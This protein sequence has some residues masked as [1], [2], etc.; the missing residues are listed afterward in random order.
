MGGE[1]PLRVFVLTRC[2]EALPG[3]LENLKSE[4]WIDNQVSFLGQFSKPSLEAQT[5]VGFEWLV[6]ASDRLAPSSLEK[7]RGA[8]EP[9][10]NLV[11]QQG[12]EH[13]SEVFYRA[14]AAQSVP[15]VTVL[16]DYDDVLSPR[17]IENVKISVEENYEVYSFISGLVYD[18]EHRIAAQWP[19]VSNPF[20]FHVGRHGSNVFGLGNHT[21]VESKFGSQLKVIR[22]PSPM[23]VKIVHGQNMGGDKISNADRPIFN[24]RH[25]REFTSVDFSTPFVPVRD[26]RRVIAHSIVFVR[27]SLLRAKKMWCSTGA[28]R[29]S[30]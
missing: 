21:R 5:D 3:E 30:I 25:L 26:F 2:A 19:H 4:E 6:S 20:I 17:F 12:A 23:W 1:K 13:S 22:T 8:I 28:N 9:L 18:I 24:A 15:Y 7:L 11:I 16:F 29:V 10:G 27:N 14:L